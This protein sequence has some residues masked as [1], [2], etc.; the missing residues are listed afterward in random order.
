MLE[1]DPIKRITIPQIKAHPWFTQNMD[2]VRDQELVK[3]TSLE[4]AVT[5]LEK[6]NG[7]DKPVIPSLKIDDVKPY[8]DSAE[9]SAT[10]FR[11]FVCVYKKGNV[12]A[13]TFASSQEHSSHQETHTRHAHPR[14]T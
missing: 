2:V 9:D 5:S 3:P 11:S 14:T 12:F 10:R 7:K 4:K 13:L 6:N 1:V 8:V